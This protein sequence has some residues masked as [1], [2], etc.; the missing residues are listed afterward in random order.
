MA[1]AG[2]YSDCQVRDFAIQGPVGVGGID[3]IT[4][5]GS[6]G[7]FTEGV[8][9]LKITGMR[10]DEVD[11]GIKGY[12]ESDQTTIEHNHIRF[13]YVCGID[14]QGGSG[15][16]ILNNHIQDAA[17]SGLTFVKV[18]KT[19]ITITGNVMQ[20][21]N[22]GLNAILITDCR[23]FTVANNYSE[24][25]GPSTAQYFC[26]MINSVAGYVGQN[27][28]G[29]YIGADLIYI[30]ATCEGIDIGSNKH[31]SS[32]GN[33]LNLVRVE[34]GATSITIPG[35]QLTSGLTTTITGV[36]E[37]DYVADYL[38]FSRH[39]LPAVYTEPVI[40]PMINSVD[41]QTT[42]NQFTTVKVFDIPA[43][44]S[45]TYLVTA[46]AVT[47]NGTTT[48]LVTITDTATVSIVTTLYA[49]PGLIATITASLREIHVGTST[50][51]NKTIT[52]SLIRIA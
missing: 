1:G 49:T 44:E 9:N 27:E 31:S 23:G 25:V 3:G 24:S 46:N 14:H 20:G 10:M 19:A 50:S 16:R 22:I 2:W 13:F 41:N 21:N 48:A 7:D 32:G 18:A 15:V 42:V 29:A 52:Y 51:G 6:V 12:W 26:K 4:V 28:M 30:D 11:I 36:A 38:G 43:A 35:K 40:A 5:G 39:N 8:G 45:A 17:A 37:C 34:V 33:I 47:Y